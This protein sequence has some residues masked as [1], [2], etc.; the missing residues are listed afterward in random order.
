[1]SDKKSG[2]GSGG[3]G[4]GAFGGEGTLDHYKSLS[5]VSV[6]LDGRDFSFKEKYRRKATPLKGR[7]TGTPSKSAL[8]DAADRDNIRA[9]PDYHRG[10]TKRGKGAARLHKSEKIMAP[11][12]SKRKKGRMGG[13]S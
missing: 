13:R 10:G 6:D 9:V 12:K 2:G 3:G 7:P 4:G 8:R 1:M 5:P 11:K